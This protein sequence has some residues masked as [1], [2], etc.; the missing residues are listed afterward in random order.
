MN[1]N[2][3]SFSLYVHIPYCISKCPYCDFN[4]HVVSRI[5]EQRYTGALIR[6]LKGYGLREPW[7]KRTLRSIFFGGGTPSTFDPESIERVLSSAASLFPFEKEIEITL[8]SN[9]GTADVA[10]FKGYRSCGVNRISLGA[11]SFQDHLLKFL[12]RIHSADET[13]RAVE[14]VC[15]AGFDN[16]NLDLIYAIPG[17]SI[18]DLK[19]DLEEAVRF[20]PPH[21]SA[22][23][24]TFED[25]TP[26]YQEYRAGKLQPLP[27]E[28]EIDMVELVEETLQGAGLSRYEISN[29]GRSGFFCQHNL[30][31]WQSGDYLGIGAGAHSYTA[32]THE[33]SGQR[34]HNEKN[35]G[36]YMEKIEREGQAAMGEEK[37]DLQTAAG[38]FMF[39]GLR[40]LEGIPVQV[41]VE[42]FGT[43]PKRFYP[44]ISD[45]I[46]HGLME[47]KKGR[48]SLTRQGLLVAN[49]LFVNFV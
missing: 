26:F 49:S 18:F 11:Q 38:E 14:M 8:E 35:P 36:R 19:A 23:N 20:R 25:G 34:W 9:P 5:P 47:E 21:V 3:P 41:F 31:Y 6:E 44:Q 42:R 30:N 27:E 15:R 37:R 24:L 7:R 29:Y 10:H 43:E 22:Y 33:K 40:L 39:V 32:I 28:E 16:F 13:R 45:W 48:L 46:E 17:Q 1:S 2:R 4:S 12:G